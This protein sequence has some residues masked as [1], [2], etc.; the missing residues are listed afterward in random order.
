MVKPP[1]RLGGGMLHDRYPQEPPGGY[2]R[3]FGSIRGALRP[4]LVPFWP[5]FGPGGRVRGR[6]LVMADG[7]A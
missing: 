2:G 1:R 7:A 3:R 5:P 4:N 6:R